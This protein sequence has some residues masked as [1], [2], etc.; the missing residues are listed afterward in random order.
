MGKANVVEGQTS[1]V[2]LYRAVW[3]WHFIASL[4]V[5]PFMVVMAVTGTLYSF[6]NSIER[7]LYG[8]SQT[9]T[10]GDS[11]LDYESIAAAVT[12]AAPGRIVKVFVPEENDKSYLFKVEGGT[13][14]HTVWANPY[15]GEVLLQLESDSM[16]I[17]VVERLHTSLLAGQ[18]GRYIVEA[19]ACWAF[20]MFVT[21]LF[22]WWPRGT[23]GW[24][25][26]FRLPRGKGR[27]FWRS[28]HLWTGFI[29]AI[30]V[31]PMI[32]TGLFWT[33]VWGKAYFNA[34]M[35][36]KH[37]SPARAY[38]G[39]PVFAKSEGAVMPMDSL[40]A[41]ARSEGIGGTLE[42]RPPK[43]PK[44]AMLMRTEEAAPM[45]QQLEIHLDTKS[46]EVVHSAT[47][48]RYPPMA[49]YRSMA[50]RF[51][52]GHLYGNLNWAQ[53]L[54]AALSVIV[55]SVSGFVAWWKR[56]PAGSLGVPAVPA[57]TRVGIGMMLIIVVLAIFFP[58][59]GATLVLALLFDRFILQQAGWFQSPP[60]KT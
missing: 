28:V 27:A 5:L 48:D 36:A 41:K 33:D 45:S 46:G 29:A 11:K 18:T 3:K 31:L 17:A 6:K 30:L 38:G 22:L 51:H 21:G 25:D 23:R 42:F 60:A 40:I 4:F 2:A 10:P 50:A 55:L 43:A 53:N 15:T 24:V 9:I 37:F 58:L 12:E 35:A 20:V 44:F 54:I 59:V 56:R 19:L 47:Y 14:S 57:N 16:A 1:G 49:L 52:V 39:P 7:S 32:V 8:S 13:G 26:A 34:Q